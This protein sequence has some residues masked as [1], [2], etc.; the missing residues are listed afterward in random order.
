MDLE[1]IYTVGKRIDACLVYTTRDQQLFKVIRAEKD[2]SKTYDC[3]VDKCNAKISIQDGMCSYIEP[4]TIHSHDG[5]QENDYKQFN[6][7]LNLKHRCQGDPNLS[8]REIFNQ[9]CGSTSDANFD[10]LKSTMINH[11]RLMKLKAT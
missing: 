4:F 3:H 5:N 6:L 8:I 2:G 1:F 10:E 7:E 11:R 9:V